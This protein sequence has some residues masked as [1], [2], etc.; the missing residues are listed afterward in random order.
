[1][2]IDLLNIQYKNI[3][4]IE[5]EIYKSDY[6]KIIENKTIYEINIIDYKG[7][8]KIK[9]KI[10]D[11]KY[12]L[13]FSLIGLLI[14]YFLSNLIFRIDIITNDKNMKGKISNILSDNGI[15]LYHLKKSYKQLQNI[16]NKIL[17]KYKNEIDWLE[18]ENEGSRYIIR[19][20][21]RLNSD[22]NH[23]IKYQ[24]IVAKKDSIIYSMDISSGQIIKNRFD[25]VK[26]GDIIVSGYIYMNEE[27]KNTVKASGKVY[28]EVWY[29]VKATT[30][31]KQ[32][33]KTKTGKSKKT[34]VFKFLNNEFQ[35]F[36]FNKYKNYDKKDNQ[37]IKNRLLPF[38]I[39]IQKQEEVNITTENKTYEEALNNLVNISKEKMEKKLSK[40]EYI[41]DFKILNETK[42]NDKLNIEIFF[43]V[44][45]DISEY[46]EIPK[47][48]DLH[49]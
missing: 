39:S 7:L 28:G 13:L 15:S 45:E 19:Y 4:E 24:H 40:N 16:K 42:Q 21:P 20:E 31:L 17:T 27:I 8:M 6:D 11:Y 23:D 33:I 2:G 9:R 43:S 22:L 38:S 48:E 25:Y 14:I 29:K 41:K 26:K 18:I 10:L 32:T 37:I 5:I 35:P 36:N 1:M 12:I 34:L 49:E 30:K 44:I 46:Q 3:N 47:H